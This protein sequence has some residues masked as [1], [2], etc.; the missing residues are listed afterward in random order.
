MGALGYTA[1]A[2][3]VGGGGYY[4][5]ANVQGRAPPIPNVTVPGKGAGGGTS[6]GP[7][8]KAF[9]GGDQGFISLKLDKVE[10]VNHNTKKFTFALPDPNQ[11]SGLPIACMQTFEQQMYFHTNVDAS[12]SCVNHKISRRWHG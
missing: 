8:D 10:N 12:N 7:D 1:I 9:T 2:A 11:T 6:S 5:Y 3:A 4:Y